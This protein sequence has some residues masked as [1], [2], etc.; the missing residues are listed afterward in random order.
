MGI[1]CG[2]ALIG[3]D[4]GSQA[5]GDIEYVRSAPVLQRVILGFGPRGTMLKVRFVRS[6]GADSA[7][8]NTENVRYSSETRIDG[9]LKA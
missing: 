9:W 6:G 5:W 4:L 7:F 8:W 3:Q 1:A 2:A